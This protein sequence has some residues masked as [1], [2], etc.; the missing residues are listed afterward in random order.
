MSSSRRQV[1]SSADP[2]PLSEQLAQREYELRLLTETAE[3]IATQLDLDQVL[4]L[5]A[6]QSMALIQADAILIPMLDRDREHY[7]YAATRGRNA[8]IILHQRFPVS[9]GMCGWVLSNERSLLF[10][11]DHPDLMDVKTVWEEG[12]ESALLV[13]LRSRGRIVGGLS[14]L[15]KRGGASFTE[16]DLELLTLFAGQV[17]TA[18]ENAQIFQDLEAEKERAEAANRAK[19]EFLAVMSHELRTPL[20]AMLGMNELLTETPLSEEQ[21][22]YVQVQQRSAGHLLDLIDD[23]LDLARIERGIVEPQPELFSPR[24]LME[25]VRGVVANRVQQKRLEFTTR[26]AP[27][28]PTRLRGDYRRLRQIVVNLVGNACKFTNIGGVTLSLE[29]P[30]GRPPGTLRVVVSDTGI[31][32]PKAKQALVFDAFAQADSSITRQFGGSGLGLNIVKRL[33]EVL[34]GTIELKSR[35][36]H[37]TTFT[38]ELTFEAMEAREE[39]VTPLLHDIRVLLVGGEGES[40][41][42]LDRE[43]RALGADCTLVGAHDAQRP[44]SS[45]VNRSRQVILIDHTRREDAFSIPRYVRHHGEWPDT[46]IVLLTPWRRTADKVE[47]ERLDVRMIQK[48]A[49]HEEWVEAILV[50]ARGAERHTT[51]APPYPTPPI[52]RELA[53][54]LA[55]DAEDNVLLIRSYLSRTNHTL[56]V[57]KNGAEALARFRDGE[58]DLVLMDLQMPD[59]DGY[60][61]TRRIREWERARG[62]AATPI[63]ALTAHALKGDAEKSLAAGCDAHLT[64]PIRKQLLLDTLARY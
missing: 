55:E 42:A 38:V 46:P 1:V 6:E 40:A 20:N 36:G 35:E 28:L 63:L 29:A 64:K 7:H 44:P 30:E 18:I 5:V 47:A 61:A 17:G 9:V 4:E 16:R 10:G 48:P 34:D 26:L 50:A 62:W 54:L 53:I 2:L 12:M 19:S 33:V 57:A 8:E 45:P 56:E 58:F 49:G 37:G 27:E 15:G 31:G 51:H 32:I 60:E 21:H 24:D 22:G 41:H 23:I 39:E 14:G 25:W 3:R 11:H 43:L 52:S 13:P 59:M